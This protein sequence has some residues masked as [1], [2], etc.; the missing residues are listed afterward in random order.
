VLRTAPDIEGTKERIADTVSDTWEH[1]R[2]LLTPYLDS[3]SARVGPALGEAR[4]RLRDD[5]A[6]EAMERA[7][8]ALQAL[9]G[10][11]A[12]PAR[13]WPLALGCLLLGGAAGIAAAVT[14]RPRDRQATIAPPTPF[15][16]ETRPT[17]TGTRAGGSGTEQT[18]A[19]TT[20]PAD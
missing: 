12:K 18:S 15:P 9:R 16:T 20:A 2:D 13:R 11:R 8:A 4:T 17:A 19:T 5:V 3:A 7:A 1:A 14:L 6:P 10:V